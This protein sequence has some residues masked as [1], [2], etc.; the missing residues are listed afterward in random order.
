MSAEE[1]VREF[2]RS[3]GN[4]RRLTRQLYN[5][6]KPPKQKPQK[7]FLLDDLKEAGKAK[8][9]DIAAKTGYSPQNLCILY[10]GLEKDGLIAREV[11]STDRRNTYYFLTDKGLQTLEKNKSKARDAIKELFGQLS[12]NDLT[13]LKKSLE[14][15][16]NIIEKVM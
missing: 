12:D 11:D 3:V 14:K 16:N 10:N 2:F 6:I 7:I 5:Y 15:V 13:E 9:K 8:L 1:V 4:D